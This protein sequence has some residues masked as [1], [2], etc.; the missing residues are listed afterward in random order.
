MEMNRVHFIR[1]FARK[2][3]LKWINKLYNEKIAQDA[4]YVRLVKTR[5]DF[6]DFTYDYYLRATV[7]VMQLRWIW[8]I[9]S[10]QS[11]RMLN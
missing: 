3:L 10:R 2:N 9:Y 5:K 8:L 1:L 11:R 4:Q 7:H 6:A